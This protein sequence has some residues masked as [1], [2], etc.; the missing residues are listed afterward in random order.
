MPLGK[1]ENEHAR[2]SEGWPDRKLH[3]GRERRERA[4]GQAGFSR[5]SGSVLSPVFI[6]DKWECERP[7][8]SCGGAGPS[9]GSWR[10]RPPKDAPEPTRPQLCHH[11]NEHLLLPMTQPRLS[12]SGMVSSSH[13]HGSGQPSAPVKS[14]LPLLR[15]IIQGPR[16]ETVPLT[17]VL[18]RLSRRWLSAEPRPQ[19]PTG[20]R[21]LP[22]PTPLT[23]QLRTQLPMGL[24]VSGATL[25]GSP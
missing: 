19:E 20:G 1:L 12:W 13:F 14:S 17:S 16:Q 11:D 25:L 7:G 10:S 15:G 8:R 9:S 21:L 6:S 5:E 23:P 24:R 18:S 2:L 4:W 3:K 22:L